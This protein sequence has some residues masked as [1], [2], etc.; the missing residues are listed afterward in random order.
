MATLTHGGTLPDNA[1]KTDFYNIID[2][3]TVT[4]IV[5]ADL[6]ASAAIAYSKLA[7]AGAVQLGD[8]SVVIPQVVFNDNEIVS[9]QN[10]MVTST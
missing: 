5:S 1:N 9:Y 8:L 4:Q 6:S 7:L 3:A 2:N 10:E